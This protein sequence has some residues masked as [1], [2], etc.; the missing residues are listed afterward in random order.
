MTAHAVPLARPTFA[1][2]L[3]A[4]K[5][6]L[7]D[8]ALLVLLIALVILLLCTTSGFGSQANIS[9]ILV[10]AAIPLVLVVPLALLVMS[11][12]VDLSI[13]S[14]VAFSA[15]VFGQLSVVQQWPL[16]AATLATVAVGAAI[17]GFNAVLVTIVGIDSLIV[18]LATLA[19]FRGLAQVIAPNPVY[20]F[21]DA[22]TGFA[23]GNLLGIP[24]LALCGLAVVI[25][26]WYLMARS[27][28]G[29]RIRA[30]GVNREAAYLSGIKTQAISIGLFVAVGAAAGCAAVMTAARINSVPAQ[31]TGLNL[32][33]DILTAVLLG[34]VALGGGRGKIRGLVIGVLFLGVLANGLTLMN[35]AAAW[36]VAA[37]GILLL[38][39]A[40]MDRLGYDVRP[41]L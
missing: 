3:A 12:N 2:V 39:A 9:N 32:E 33:I 31:T 1:P 10:Q 13:G 4:V 8:N 29:N 38:A 23:A 11:G 20:G 26:G 6:I 24:N 22:L 36:A 28:I 30:L 19:A 40:I 34:G 5:R 25:I 16:W 7:L 18:T 21:D 17:G 35:V 27:P 41:K 37:K 14:N 15:A